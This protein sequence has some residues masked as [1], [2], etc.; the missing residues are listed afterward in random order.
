MASPLDLLNSYKQKINNASRPPTPSTTVG[1]GGSQSPLLQNF[2]SGFHA[3]QGRVTG[4]FTPKG[5]AQFPIRGGE[6]SQTTPRVPTSWN[7]LDSPPQTGEQRF[8][9][10]YPKNKPTNKSQPIQSTKPKP[11]VSSETQTNID[12][13]RGRNA[14]TRVDRGIKNG[15]V[16]GPLRNTIVGGLVYAAGDALIPHI[17]REAVRGAMVVTGQDT[18]NY[19]TAYLQGKPVVKN[20]GGVSYNIA[21]EEGMAGYRRALA[22]G[23]KPSA[24]AKPA[25]TDK[26]LPYG[27]LPGGS[28]PDRSAAQPGTGPKNNKVGSDSDP[29]E[30]GLQGP[31]DPKGPPGSSR[32]NANG[33][34]SYGKDLSSL[35]Q[36]TKAFTGGYEVADIE[37]A[38]QSEDLPGAYQTG[39]NKINPGQTA[40][41]LPEGAAPSPLDKGLAGAEG[42]T[43]QDTGYTIGESSVPGT[44]GRSGSA[45]EGSSSKPDIAE[46]V[47]TIR[48]NR[49]SGRGSRRDP[50]N[51]GEDADMF[52]GPEPSDASLVSP[53]YAN[54]KRNKIR[55]TFLDHEG[56]SVQAAA[57]ANAVA[58]YGKDSNA[59]ARFNVGGEL[60]YAKEG[61]QQK[62]KNAAMMG[63]DPREFL[64]IPTTPDTQPDSPCRY[65][66]SHLRLQKKLK[67][68]TGS[69]R[70]SSKRK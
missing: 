50:R 23:Q 53:M 7:D 43:M 61:M 48:M 45:Q 58:G 31:G 46:E 29:D 54:A 51:R 59:D 10:E 6:Y 5:N 16:T 68:K 32:V 21:T 19:D 34:V 17:S 40:Y 18:T 39:S 27:S 64:D 69:S 60:V 49:N 65:R 57:A 42:L 70:S 37:T 63:K 12:A 28:N 25:N 2:K 4:R 22:K 9:K 47:R 14:Q 38:F 55:S 33:L 62:A 1:T 35:N 11:T 66:V 15:S 20:V 41:E 44:V 30:P 8:N 24:P 26:P 67:Q 56:S 13:R 3:G 52:G 36:F